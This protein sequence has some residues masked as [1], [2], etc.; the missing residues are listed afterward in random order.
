M[1]FDWRFWLLVAVL[2]LLVPWGTHAL[3]QLVVKGMT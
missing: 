2:G 1:R 3:G